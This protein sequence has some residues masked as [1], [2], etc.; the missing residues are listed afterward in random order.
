[1]LFSVFRPAKGLKVMDFRARLQLQVCQVLLQLCK[2]IEAIP[3]EE[4][5]WFSVVNCVSSARGRKSL[6]SEQSLSSSL[7]SPF[8]S[9]R[10]IKSELARDRKVSDFSVVTRPTG[11]KSVH[12]DSAGAYRALN[13]SVLVRSVSNPLS[14]GRHSKRRLIGIDERELLDP[15][16]VRSGRRRRPAATR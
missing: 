2:G 6:N 14:R 11:E 1:M 10:A 5:S 4:S 13:V 12:G 7:S 16:A 9:C 8:D 15:V 3:F